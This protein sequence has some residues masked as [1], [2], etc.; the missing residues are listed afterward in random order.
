MKNMENEALPVEAVK[1]LSSIDLKK[2]EPGLIRLAEKLG[3]PFLTFASED[4][5]KVPGDFS[6]S[7]FV[8]KRT[9]VDCICERAAAA[10][11][12]GAVTV[13][14]KAENGMTFALAE[15]P[16]EISF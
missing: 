10:A 6:G 12:G 9:G 5:R 14:K 8:K 1:T 15:Y 3:V 4:L 13:T 11:A 7:G 16:E 2:S